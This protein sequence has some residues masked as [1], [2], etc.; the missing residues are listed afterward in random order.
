[1]S[2]RLCECIMC[3]GFQFCSGGYNV[4]NYF[5]I[6]IIVVIRLKLGKNNNQKK[7]EETTTTKDIRPN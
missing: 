3:V 4:T 1:M 5:M 7:S 6:I 2:V